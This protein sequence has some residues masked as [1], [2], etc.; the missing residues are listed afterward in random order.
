MNVAHDL[1]NKKLGA[2]SCMN[3]QPSLSYLLSLL[4]PFFKNSLKTA[5]E[6][7]IFLKAKESRFPSNS[8]DLF[9]SRCAPCYI[10]RTV[11]SRNRAGGIIM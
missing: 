6:R 8:A 10:E 4:P 2:N 9:I 11:V 3:E 5:R 7:V 1:L